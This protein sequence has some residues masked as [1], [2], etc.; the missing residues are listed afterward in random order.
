MFITNFTNCEWTLS[1]I[2]FLK[3]QYPVE[4]FSWITCASI[5]G[6]SYACGNEWSMLNWYRLFNEGKM[7]GHDWSQYERFTIITK[8][9][10]GK[11][12][13]IMPFSINQLQEAFPQVL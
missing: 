11:V 4:F 6:M 3:A 12:V 5:W 9:V 7:G 13:K 1:V 10:T 8:D 2:R